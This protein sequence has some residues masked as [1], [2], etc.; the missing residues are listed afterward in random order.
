M[1]KISPATLI[2]LSLLV[3]WVVLFG[4]LLKRDY[5]IE[6]LDLREARVIQKGR[7]ESFSGVYFQ[8][9]RIGFVNNRLTPVAD[10]FQLTQEA[11]LLLNILEQRHRVELKIS[12]R[13]DPA[14]LLRNFDFQLESPFYSMT[15]KGQVEGKTVRFT[16][17]TGKE[18]IN[19]SVTLDHPPFLAT[20]QR[21]YLLERKP[22]PGSKIRIPY[23]DPVSLSGKDTVLE[24]KGYE[25]ILL[26][27]R[28]HRLHHFTESFSGMQINSWLDDDGK[29]IKEESPAGFTF[30]S[31]PEFKATDLPTQGREILS[32]VSVPVTGVMP[33]DYATREKLL[34]RLSFPEE[35]EVEI[36]KDRQRLNHGV[37]SVVLEPLPAANARACEGPPAELSATPYIQ[38][39]HSE[40][41]G[42]V[43]S[44]VEETM[45]DLKKVRAIADWVF[46]TLEKRPVLGIPDALTTLRMKKGDCNEHAALFAAMARN[47]GIP[48]RIVAGVTYHQQSFYYHAWNEVCLDGQWLSLDTTKNQIPA[49]VTHIK[50]VEGETKEQIKIGGL[51]GRLQIEIVPE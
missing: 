41:S 30:L 16:I 36:D 28:I 14:M 34:F 48:T 39:E 19:D 50:F 45:N 13:L 12:A 5:F 10:G 29:V 8:N 38:S 32:S 18:E 27:G 3:L 9:E 33:G 40:I 15:A 23:F 43:D 21:G 37:L 7:E 20:N 24:Y 35:A 44:L 26:A 31:E 42:L 47:A 49:D 2:R 22:E 4:L 17:T 25:K 11:L 6:R 51:L 1:Q 46:K